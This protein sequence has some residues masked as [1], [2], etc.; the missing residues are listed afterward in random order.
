MSSD[1]HPASMIDL[2]RLSDAEIAEWQRLHRLVSLSEPQA[3]EYYDQTGVSWQ[4]RRDW[5]SDATVRLL[6]RL[7][8]ERLALLNRVAELEKGL[9][10]F[11]DHIHEFI[12]SSLSVEDVCRGRA[13]LP[14]TKEQAGT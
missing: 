9:R 3:R 10:P 2:E 1:P 7:L 4:Q 6:P 8:F 11:V 12:G 13:L 14:T 5:L